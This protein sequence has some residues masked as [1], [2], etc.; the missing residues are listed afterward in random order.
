MRLTTRP[1]R[2]DLYG[3]LRDSLRPL[4]CERPVDDAHHVGGVRLGEVEVLAVDVG[5]SDKADHRGDQ[6][7]RD[8]AGL[9]KGEISEA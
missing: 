5:G 6:L 1:T 9:L 2:I 7:R 4:L 3:E 8:L